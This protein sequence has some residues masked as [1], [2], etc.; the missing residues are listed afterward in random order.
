MKKYFEKISMAIKTHNPSLNG[1]TS[2]LF[3][4]DEIGALDEK[5]PAWDLAMN[6]TKINCN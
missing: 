2:P 3:L 6:L 4:L 5:T 1:I